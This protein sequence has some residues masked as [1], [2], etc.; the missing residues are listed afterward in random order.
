MVWRSVRPTNVA[1]ASSRQCG[2]RRPGK[3]Q[4]K[5]L[6]RVGA[7]TRLW[8]RVGVGVGVGAGTR[9]WVRVRSG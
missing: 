2:A 1:R 8:V 7:G 6:V 5:G 9:L 4:G 3:G